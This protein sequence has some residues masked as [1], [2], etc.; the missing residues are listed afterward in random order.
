MRFALPSVRTG[1]APGM[2]SW[3]S[4]ALFLGCA[5]APSFALGDEVLVVQKG[6]KFYPSELTIKPGD[7]IR[8]QNEDG[9]HHNAFSETKGLEFNIRSQAPKSVKDIALHSEGTAEIRCAFHP[10]MKLIVTV[11]K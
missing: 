3:A 7:R 8:F 9:M 4:A 10:E 11:V 2:K 5:S 6:K 1:V